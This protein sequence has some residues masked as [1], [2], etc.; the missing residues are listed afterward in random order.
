[1]PSELEE[2]VALVTGGGRGIGAGI[3]RELAAAGMRVAVAARTQEQVVDTAREIDGLA[4]VGDA[5]RREDVERWVREVET[6]LG[7]LDLLVNNAGM[8]GPTASF[9]DEHPDAW[10]RVF[11][12]NLRGAFLCCHAAVPGMLARGGGRIVNVASGAAY[13]PTTGMS[14]TAYGP[15]KAALHRFSE[16]LAAQLAPQNVFVFSISPGLVRT[17]MTEGHFSDDAPWTP[18]ECAPRLVR[19]LATGRLDRLAGRYLHAEHDPPEAL[20]GRIEQILAEDLNAI[21]LRR[22]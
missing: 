15:S 21:R 12:V 1:V 16:L 18:P 11:E 5:S 17:A 2:Q 14:S 22:E 20:E 10:W 4:L 9:T 13:L 6:V 3:A 7:P 19:A 8:S